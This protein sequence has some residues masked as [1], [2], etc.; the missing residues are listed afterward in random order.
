[1]TF[2]FTVFEMI[3]YKKAAHYNSYIHQISVKIKNKS[4]KT[5]RKL[6]KNVDR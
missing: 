3:N 6:A 5:K 2:E 1:M 4:N